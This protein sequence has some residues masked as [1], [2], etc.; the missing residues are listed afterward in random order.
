MAV[1]IGIADHGRSGSTADAWRR[2]WCRRSSVVGRV[3]SVGRRRSSVSRPSRAE[4]VRS[5]R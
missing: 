1:V 3:A 2:P 5:Q 4:S